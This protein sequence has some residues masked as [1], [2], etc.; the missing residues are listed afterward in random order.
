MASARDVDRWLPGGASG[1]AGDLFLLVVAAVLALVMVVLLH[2]P[3]QAIGLV[4]HPD[5]RK[6]HGHAVPLAGGLAVALVTILCVWLF[7][8]E[9]PN[10][11]V[12]EAATGLL[13]VG[14]LDDRYRLAASVRLFWQLMAALWMVEAGGLVVTSLGALGE[15]DLMAKPFT[16][17]CIVTFIN[18]A[19]MVDGADGLLAGTLVPVFIGVAVITEGPLEAAALITAGALLGFLVANWPASPGSRRARLRTFLGN[20]GAMFVAVLVAATLI[21]CTQYLKDLRPGAVPFMVLIPLAEL[22][23]S[24]V[25]RVLNGTDALSADTRHFHHRLLAAGM[26]RTA[27]ATSYLV[28]SGVSVAVGLMLS[29]LVPADSWL[30]W[31]IAAA[32]LTVLTFIGVKAPMV[33]A[34]AVPQEPGDLLVASLTGRA[35]QPTLRPEP[36]E[37]D[38]GKR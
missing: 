11:R 29:E 30:R 27:L 14:M 4:D 18:A 10:R 37:G 5:Q 21:Y 19:N 16:I 17:L 20:G 35:P 9:G 2:Q 34:P 1:S 26:S 36:I 38:R 32:I 12:L 31:G 3:C 8:P 7:L 13:L 15:L 24:V 23:N 22:A 25:R 28:V 33:R 6:Q